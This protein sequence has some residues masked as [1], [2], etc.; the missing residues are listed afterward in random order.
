M[1]F[2]CTRTEDSMWNDWKKQTALGSHTKVNCHS[3]WVTQKDSTPVG[4]CDSCWTLNM[5][6][7]V[8][9]Y[10]YF[11]QRKTQE[12]TRGYFYN[13]KGNGRKKSRDKNGQC[14]FPFKF[15]RIHS[16]A[17]QS[18]NVWVFENEHS[19]GE[20]PWP[21]NL[22][23]I[24]VNIYIFHLKGA[25]FELPAVFSTGPCFQAKQADVTMKTTETIHLICLSGMAAPVW[26]PK[27]HC[28]IKGSLLYK[29]ASWNLFPRS[30]PGTVE[31]HYKL[32]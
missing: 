11:L 25:S 9:R 7:E 16:E 20:G 27:H 13:G 4:R 12:L 10:C 18:S 23:H 6:V 30:C 26:V 15:N 24:H 29:S 2:F 5:L 8:S 1:N 3:T 21:L 28:S 17:D 14:M 31:W 32:S 19:F 22:F